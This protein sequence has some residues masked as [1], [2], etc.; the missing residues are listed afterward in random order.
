MQNITLYKQIII[1]NTC[2]SNYRVIYLCNVDKHVN[3]IYLG[4]TSPSTHCA[5]DVPAGSL[6]GRGN[7]Y[8]LIGQD[9]AQKLPGIGK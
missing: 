3:L 6:K 5:D 7:Q 1:H 4:L 2:V 9:Y 8:I